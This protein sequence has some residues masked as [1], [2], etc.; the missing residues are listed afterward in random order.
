MKLP[1]TTSA[2]EAA[3]TGKILDMAA[4][5]VKRAVLETI[6]DGVVS[7][8]SRGTILLVNE[9]TERIFGYPSGELTGKP[10][11]ILI[12]EY[13]REIHNSGFDRYNRT[14]K[15]NLHTWSALELIG[16]HK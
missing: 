4:E 16:R 14:G 6:T 11:E 10:L 5:A 2:P 3:L 7:V 12:P 13:L 9:P 8:D 1:T 15:K